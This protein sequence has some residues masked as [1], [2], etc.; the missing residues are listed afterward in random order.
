[1]GVYEDLQR[2]GLIAQTTDEEQIRE[3]KEAIELREK[4]T[5]IEVVY[6]KMPH[7]EYKIDGKKK[8]LQLIRALMRNTPFYILDEPLNHLD[9]EGKK[10]TE[11]LLLDLVKEHGILI[12][13]K[14]INF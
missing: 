8:K 10:E 9:E 5:D 1:M 2:R 14:T 6:D 4:A 7:I 11:C 12:I 13:T 3:F